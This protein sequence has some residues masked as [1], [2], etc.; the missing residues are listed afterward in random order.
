[1]AALAKQKQT[2]KYIMIITRDVAND[3]AKSEVVSFLT[4]EDHAFALSL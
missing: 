3:Q 1:M 2:T 4:K